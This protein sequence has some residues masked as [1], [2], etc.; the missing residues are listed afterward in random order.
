MKKLDNN[1][2]LLGFG[3]S[4]QPGGGVRIDDRG[5]GVFEARIIAKVITPKFTHLV[6]HQGGARALQKSLIWYQ[7]SAI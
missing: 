7:K 3:R 6:N 2:L 4:E 5:E 1:F